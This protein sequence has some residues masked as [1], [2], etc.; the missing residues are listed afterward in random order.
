MTNPNDVGASTSCQEHISANGPPI[1]CNSMA[2]SG[3]AVCSP[4]LSIKT[5]A[6]PC[7][8]IQKG[9]KGIFCQKGILYYSYVENLDADPQFFQLVAGGLNGRR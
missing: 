4:I 5:H 6:L 3:V 9:V 2:L 7:F 1:F 8:T